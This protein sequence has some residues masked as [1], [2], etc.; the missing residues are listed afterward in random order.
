MPRR[1][2]AAEKNLHRAA[3]RF[4]AALVSKKLFELAGPATDAEEKVFAAL[5][6]NFREEAAVDREAERVFEQNRSLAA[7]M[8]QRAFLRKIREKVARD[9][10]FVL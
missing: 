8:D 6:A 4:V 9:R 2:P 5:Q 7:G 10:G 1:M 3:S